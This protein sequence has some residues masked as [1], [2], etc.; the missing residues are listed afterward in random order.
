MK[1][2]GFK[3]NVMSID[4]TETEHDLLL[5]NGLQLYIDKELGKN[6][7]KVIDAKNSNHNAKQFELGDE[8]AEELISLAVNNALREK[9]EG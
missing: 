6:K 4:L 2:L 5:R 3:G 8:F 1:I 7:I 9:I